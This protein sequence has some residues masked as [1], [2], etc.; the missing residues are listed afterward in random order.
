MRYTERV[1]TRTSLS[2]SAS[3]PS[4]ALAAA[5]PASGLSVEADLSSGFSSGLLSNFLSFA[6]ALSF[7]CCLARSSADVYM[8]KAI[9]LLSGDHTGPPAPR[10]RSVIFHDSPPPLT[11][12]I[13]SCGDAPR[14]GPPGPAAAPPAGSGA[15]TNTSHLPSGDQRG[16][17]SCLPSVMRRG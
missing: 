16:E 17:E 5:G 6:A 11:G 9:I 10:G 8:V 7:L 4:A 1:I 2:C 14:P 12:S 15:R 13:S 3:E